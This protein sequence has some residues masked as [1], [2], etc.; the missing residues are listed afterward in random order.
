MKDKYGE[1]PQ[2]MVLPLRPEPKVET[3]PA[4]KVNVVETVVVEP[5][6][7]EKVKE[8]VKVEP[9]VEI[10]EEVKQDKTAVEP[11]PRKRKLS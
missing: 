4:A 8:P 5:E 2:F 6:K 9:K 3:V 1:R 11:K 10:Q 7:E